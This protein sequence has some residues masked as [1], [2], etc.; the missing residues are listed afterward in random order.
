[1]DYEL[2]YKKLVKRLEAL[3]PGGSEF[4][5]SPDVCLHFLGRLPKLLVKKQKEIIELREQ[6]CSNQ[7]Q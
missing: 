7:K 2:E 3:T 4:H 6:I 5:D 1:M